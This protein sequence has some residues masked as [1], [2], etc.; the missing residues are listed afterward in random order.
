MKTVATVHRYQ[1]HSQ[2]FSEGGGGG[3]GVTLCQSLLSRNIV[4][5]LLKKAYKGGSRATQDPLT[6]PLVMCCF[7]IVLY[8]TFE[9]IIINKVH[10]AKRSCAPLAFVRLTRLKEV[11]ILTYFSFLTLLLFHAMLVTKTLKT[12]T[13]WSYMY[14]MIK[15]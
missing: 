13:L 14:N 6:T 2:D 4:G 10:V 5:C 8:E 3:G 1:G 9:I 11:F 15:A 7:I 12:F